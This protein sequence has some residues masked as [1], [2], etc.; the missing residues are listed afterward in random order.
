MAAAVKRGKY[1]CNAQ[2]FQ[3]LTQGLLHQIS[4]QA[5]RPE[6][7]LGIHDKV[8]SPNTPQKLLRCS[9]VGRRIEAGSVKVLD[10]RHL[11]AI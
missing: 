9:R 8:R 6:E 5:L 1:P 4:P 10:P 7:N 3:T 2:A 11:K